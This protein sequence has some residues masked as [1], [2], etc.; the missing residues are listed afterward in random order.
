MQAE[1]IQ[2]IKG[3]SCIIIY[4]VYYIAYN[5]IMQEHSVVFTKLEY[6]R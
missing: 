3:Y 1:E 4:D 5:H 6:I 2:V